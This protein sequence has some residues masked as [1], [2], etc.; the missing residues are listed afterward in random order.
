MTLLEKINKLTW[1]SEIIKL[2]DILKNF[3]EKIN[4]T[5]T[6]IE[7]LQ[8]DIVDLQNNPV[9]SRP[10]KIYTALLTQSGTDAPIATVLENTLGNI[11]WS[12]YTLGVYNAELPDAF[13]EK[14][15]TVIFGAGKS[16][17]QAGDK[18]EIYDDEGESTNSIKIIQLTFDSNAVDFF[19]GILIE[20]R[21]YE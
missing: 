4:L 13:T 2:K 7:T 3:L 21:V 19:D 18:I 16:S 10:Y 17:S 12:Y 11:V 9:D 20:I 14:K 1:F 5:E 6:T 15:T 8:T